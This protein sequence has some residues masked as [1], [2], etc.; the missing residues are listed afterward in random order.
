[1]DDVNEGTRAI[2]QW[3]LAFIL[4]LVVGGFLYYAVLPS[5]E[6]A[7]RQS[8]ENTESYVQGAVRDLANLC[9]EVEKADAAHRDLLQDTI[10]QR[11]TKLDMRDVP[12]YLQPCLQAA[13]KG[14]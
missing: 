1:V 3:T 13:R 10:R 7:R 6:N 11:Y 5:W 4:A 12:A 14:E 9:L 8:Y 2:F